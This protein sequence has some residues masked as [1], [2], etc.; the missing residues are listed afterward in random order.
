LTPRRVNAPPD[1]WPQ[2]VLAVSSANAAMQNYVRPMSPDQ[3]QSG[4]W[5]RH[6]QTAFLLRYDVPIYYVSQELLAAALQTE[7][8][9]DV[10][11]E[12][13]PFPLDASV[14]MLSKGTVRHPI[15]G[16]CPFLVQE[17]SMKEPLIVV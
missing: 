5:R 6:G 13:I 8:P 10:V 12:S 4:G 15:L 7:L 14:F 3:A 2:K 1:Y 9:H 16:N 17:L 11:F